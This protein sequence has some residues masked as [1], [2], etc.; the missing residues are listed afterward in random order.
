MTGARGALRNVV[1]AAALLLGA[2][3]TSTTLPDLPKDV[4]DAWRNVPKTEM[5]PGP[6][7]DLA[8]WWHA[9]ND[10]GLNRLVERALAQNL[11]LQQAQLRLVAARALQHKSGTQFDPQLSFHTYAQPDPN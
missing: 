6:A 1:C 7:P 8:H 11:T 3:K 10:E 4:P 2:C 9:F 5:P